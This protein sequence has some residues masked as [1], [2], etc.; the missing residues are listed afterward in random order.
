M[1][2]V[3]IYIIAFLTTVPFVL[4][5]LIYYF[6]IKFH[7]PVWKAVHSAVNWTTL[8]YMIAVVLILNMTFDL[9]VIGIV[10]V[11]YLFLLGLFIYLQWKFETEVK[12]TKAF[13][14]AWRIYFLLFLFLYI[15]LV[16]IGIIIELI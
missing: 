8:F 5:A 11:F 7:Q 2:D 14:L 9:N 1:V 15:C 10:L 16:I 6:F 12:I 13:K 4:T 3:I